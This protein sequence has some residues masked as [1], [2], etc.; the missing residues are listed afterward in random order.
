MEHDAILLADSGS[1]K[2]T[3]ALCGT[4]CRTLTTCGLN[5]RTTSKEQ[6]CQVCEDVSRWVGR[7]PALRLFFY[8]AG[9]G[10]RDSQSLVRSYL[11]EAF[12]RSQIHVDSDLMGACVALCGNRAG[13]VGILGTGSNA[14]YYDGTRIVARPCS[15]GY[16]LGDEGSGNHIGRMLLKDYFDRSMPMELS[17]MFQ[18]GYDVDIETVLD[19]LYRRPAPNR[20]LAHFAP[21]ALQHRQHPYIVQL[22]GDAFTQYL[23]RQVCGLAPQATVLHLVGSVADAFKEEIAEA[24]RPLGIHIGKVVK[25]PIEGMI[26]A[27]AWDSSPLPVQPAGEI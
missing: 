3:W 27:A 2:T 19:S 25:D 22:L 4:D 16:I 5:P 12:P 26:P 23:Q 21:F 20:Y 15:L 17:T 8:G 10:T 13:L 18:D 24:A 14:C 1:T 11:S 6:F 9:C 7:P